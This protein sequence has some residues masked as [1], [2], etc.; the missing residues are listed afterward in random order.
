MLDEFNKVF[1]AASNRTSGR[2]SSLSSFAMT[3]CEEKNKVE[4]KSSINLNFIFNI[5]SGIMEMQLVL[6]LYN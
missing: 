2:A 3:K 4:N 6:G 5:K 1:L